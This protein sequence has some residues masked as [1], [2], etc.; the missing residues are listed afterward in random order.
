MSKENGAAETKDLTVIDYTDQKTMA[1]IK[2][3][4]ARGATPEEYAVFARFASSTG[5]N[6]FKKE[7]WFIKGKGG[8]VQMMTGINGFYAIA[9]SHPQYDGLV[10]EWITDDK[11]KLIGCRSSVYRKDRKFPA[12]AE[13]YLEEYQKPYGNWKT[14]KR[15]MIR[16]CADSMALRHAFPQEL[17]GLHTV[18]EMGNEYDVSFAG[19]TVEVEPTQEQEKELYDNFEHKYFFDKHADGKDWTESQLEKVE[20]RCNEK[21]IAY[22]REGCCFLT[23]T[24][25]E[26]AE[27]YKSL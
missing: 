23:D 27:K 16:K 10:P 5:L 18:E 15:V 21:G 20:E 22:H 19:Q 24:E 12:V 7:I 26:G 9:N 2:N 17:N 4:V 8:D 3:T 14:M 6:P 1:V 25:I 11:G 13:A